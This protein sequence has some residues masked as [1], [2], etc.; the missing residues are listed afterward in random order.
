MLDPN[1]IGATVRTW[2]AN[3]GLS[4]ESF[5]RFTDLT[6]GA[7]W[8]IEAKGQLKLGELE[9][10][11]AVWD[12]QPSPELSRSAPRA[13]KSPVIKLTG[14]IVDPT[15]IVIEQSLLGVTNPVPMPAEPVMPVVELPQLPGLLQIS[16]TVMSEQDGFRRFSNSEIQTFKRCRRKWWFAYHRKLRPKHDES[17]GV[18]SI[19]VD[20]HEALRYHYVADKTQQIHVQDALEA[21]IARN[22]AALK[23]KHEALGELI[24]L[25]VETQFKTESDL[26]RIIIEGYLDWLAETGADAEYEITG[27]E[28]YLEANLPGFNAVKIIGRLDARVRRISD[29]L[30]LFMDHKSVGNFPQL[31][32]VLHMN[33]QMLWYIVLEMLQ[34]DPSPIAGALYN[35]MRRV[36]RGANAKPPFY[37]RV[38]VHHNK[39]EIDAFLKRLTGTIED[40][41]KAEADL[42]EGVDHRFVVYPTPTTNCPWDCAFFQICGMTDDGSYAEGMIKNFF[43]EGD[44]LS[45]YVDPTIPGDESATSQNVNLH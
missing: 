4:R 5:A 15:P 33:E 7:V 31:T 18:R 29:G 27:S 8:R 45:Y 24:P 3:L 26:M 12:Q 39:Y 25:S 40:I 30:R 44:P 37:E 6:P 38:E 34:E 22:H 36:K 28:V 41:R 13:P 43:T 14:M 10:L 32:R 42:T 2:R 9:K 21:I 23:K 17:T 35:M 20:L 11:N 1:D 19:G 16:P